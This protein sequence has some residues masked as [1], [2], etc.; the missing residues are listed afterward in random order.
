MFTFLKPVLDDRSIRYLLYITVSN[1]SDIWF[2]VC[3]KRFKSGVMSCAECKET[4]GPQSHA[5]KTVK[6]A[7]N[8]I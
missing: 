6:L 3:L 4:D 7:L 2:Q 1:R 8:Q 5:G